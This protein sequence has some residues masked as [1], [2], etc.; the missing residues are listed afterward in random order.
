MLYATL[1]HFSNCRRYATAF[2]KCSLSQLSHAF[3]KQYN[4]QGAASG[5][6]FPLF[7]GKH[8]KLSSTWKP[9][10]SVYNWFVY[11]CAYCILCLQFTHTHKTR[12]YLHVSNVCFITVSGEFWVTSTP[13]TPLPLVFYFG[14]STI[15]SFPTYL[16]LVCQARLYLRQ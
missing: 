10:V 8:V 9:G 14:D 2:K 3:A 5:F 6:I 4:Q 12:L 1:F 15:L 13:V 16:F 7:H 11:K